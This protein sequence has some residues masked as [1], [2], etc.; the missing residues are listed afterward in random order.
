MR[1]GMEQVP[2][3]R[4]LTRN[5]RSDIISPTTDRLQGWS[6]WRAQRPNIPHR[7]L[8]EE[9]AVFAV[10]LAGTFV[11]DLKGRAC[12]VQTIHEHAF[13]RCLQPKLFLIL[14][15]THGGQRSEMVVQRGYAHARH[16]CEIFHS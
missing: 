6:A 7:C 15:R 12:G 8:A 4:P 3:R 5:R 9:T 2:S 1:E 13:P 10:E 11:S 14:K 16:F